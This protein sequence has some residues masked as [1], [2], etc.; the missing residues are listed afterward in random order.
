MMCALIACAKMYSVMA[1][2]DYRVIEAAQEL[3]DGQEVLFSPDRNF[4]PNAPIRYYLDDTGIL[5]TD[6][7]DE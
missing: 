2:M 3:L 7:S 4:I 6:E 5:H 1:K